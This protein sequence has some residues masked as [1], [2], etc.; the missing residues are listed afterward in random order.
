MLVDLYLRDREVVV[1]G[2]GNEAE[3]KILKV[4]DDG[5]KVTAVSKT[6]TKKI[7]SLAKKGKIRTIEYDL[8]NGYAPLKNRLGK[9]YVVFLATDDVRLN[10]LG[11][12][13]AKSLGAIV[14]VVDTPELCDFAMPAIAKVGKI[15]IGITTGGGSPIIAKL[16]RQRIEDLLTEEDLIHLELQ[17]YAR[18]KIRPKISEFPSRKK[19]L[20]K[21][22]EDGRIQSLI[23][24]RKLQQAKLLVDRMIERVA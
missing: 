16:L 21:I 11:V 8:E 1:F 10:K 15:R 3:L 22:V 20:W 6:F 12:D 14:C 23:K 17:E 7:S 5:A 13:F 18:K 19:F 2:G 9:L 24:E 4:F